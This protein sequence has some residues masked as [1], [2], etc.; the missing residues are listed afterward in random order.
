MTRIFFLHIISFSAVDKN[1]LTG[2]LMYVYLKYAMVSMVP[3][4]IG[5]ILVAY[6][7]VKSFG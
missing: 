4:A 6:V 5:S 2:D 7:E 3:V 1:V